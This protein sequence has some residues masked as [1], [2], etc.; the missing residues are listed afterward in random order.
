MPTNPSPP[1]RWHDAED[2][3][4]ELQYADDANIPVVCFIHAPGED[5][6]Y[7][8]KWTWTARNFMPRKE[9]C[10]GSYYIV[11]D[12]R[13]GIME[14]LEKHVIPLYRVALDNLTKLGDN[15][16]WSKL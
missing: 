2:A 6:D 1:A 13:E 11:A 5:D 4:M 15:Y 3:E 12:T 9:Y 7:P 16:Y 14:A 10:G 8:D